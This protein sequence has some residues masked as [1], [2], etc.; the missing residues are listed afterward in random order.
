M[1]YTVVLGYCA[2]PDFYI[3]SALTQFTIGSCKGGDPPLDTFSA[4]SRESLQAIHD[5][6]SLHNIDKSGF[7][8][9]GQHYMTPR[10][11][12]ASFVIYKFNS[13]SFVSLFEKWG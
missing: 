2:I 12:K 13:G 6:V 5:L 10:G 1:F 7:R 9:Y 11:L 8:L 4:Y 3:A